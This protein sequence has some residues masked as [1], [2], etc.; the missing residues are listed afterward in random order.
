ML[1]AGRIA[2]VE[3]RHRVQCQSDIFNRAREQ[4]DVILAPGAAERAVPADDAE[5]W[6]EANNAAIGC[7]AAHRRTGL[8]AVGDRPDACRNGCRRA[9]ARPAGDALEM[10]R[11]VH[12]TE[13]GQR[14]C[15]AMAK[16]IEIGL[17]Y[18]DRAGGAQARH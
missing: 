7:R 13:V 17:A 1:H 10:P 16:F 14:R 18:D 3:S 8:G 6:F 11:I 4:A 2:R 15:A 9:A 5:S 12:R